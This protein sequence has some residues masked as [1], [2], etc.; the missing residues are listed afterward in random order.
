MVT[1]AICTWNR[2]DLLRQTLTR[3]MELDV[4]ATVRWELLIVN[5]NSTDA[6]DQVIREF[7]DRLPIRSVVELKPGLSQARNCAIDA[8]RGDWLFFTDD[9]VL[10]ATDWLSAFASAVARHPEA[11]V[12]G[13]PIDPWFPVEPPGD[14]VGAYPELKKGF[15]GV[16]HD[17]PEGFV[18]REHWVFGANMA[19]RRSALNGLRFNTNVGGRLPLGDETDFIDRARQQ[20]GKVLWVPAMRVRHY[21]DPSRMTVEYL[22]K[23]RKTA[24][25]VHVRLSPVPPAPQLFQAPRW[26]WRAVLKSYVTHAWLQLLGRRHDALLALREHD[27]CRGMLAECRRMNAESRA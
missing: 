6:T 2:C 16:D 8:A 18:S 21:V 22:R 12:A 1:V 17:V 26:L 10:V 11:A 3:M 23:M 24:G 9:D 7:A 5:N 15:C 4:P 25:A 13:G 19:I 20:G 27:F 14:L